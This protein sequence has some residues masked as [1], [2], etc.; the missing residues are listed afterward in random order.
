MMTEPKSN[1]V[2]VQILPVIKSESSNKILLC[3]WN[4]GDFKDRYTGLIRAVDFKVKSM[5]CIHRFYYTNCYFQL[6]KFVEVNKRFIFTQR[7]SDGS[8]MS[9]TWKYDWHCVKG[10]SN[11]NFE[12]HRSASIQWVHLYGSSEWKCSKHHKCWFRWQYLWMVSFWRNSIP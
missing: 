9:F 6:L 10:W 2:Y 11:G 1:D 8:Y 5:H 7:T 12:F 3:K 4:E